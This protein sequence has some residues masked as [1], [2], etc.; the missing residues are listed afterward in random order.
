[1]TVH[2]TNLRVKVLMRLIKEFIGMFYKTKLKKYLLK[3]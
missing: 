2:E 1:M 3:E